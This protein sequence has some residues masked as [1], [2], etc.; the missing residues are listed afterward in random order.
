MA[1]SDERCSSCSFPVA[2]DPPFNRME[3]VVC[4]VCDKAHDLSGEG[5]AVA[6]RLEGGARL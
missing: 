1:M 3:T 6:D 2:Y 5:V 4:G